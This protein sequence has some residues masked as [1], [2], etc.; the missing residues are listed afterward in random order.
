MKGTIPARVGKEVHDNVEDP[1]DLI[2]E[3][4][5]FHLIVGSLE[6]PVVEERA[7]DDVSPGNKTPIAAVVAVIVVVVPSRP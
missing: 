2:A 1:A 5:L 7:P 3:A 6:G 4:G